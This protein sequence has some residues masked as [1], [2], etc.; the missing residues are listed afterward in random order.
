[1]THEE[2]LFD[3]PIYYH[4]GSFDKRTKG[5]RGGNNGKKRERLKKD[6]R[7][8]GEGEMK[9]QALLVLTYRTIWGDV[10]VGWFHKP[11]VGR[12]GGILTI[13]NPK[14]F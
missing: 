6:T 4:D 12:S 10:E 7:C 13:W 2:C 14:A 9:M 1:M 11:A 3:T 8:R 5:K